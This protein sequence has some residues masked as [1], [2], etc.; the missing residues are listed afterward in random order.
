MKESDIEYFEKERKIRN[1][2]FFDRFPKIKYKGLKILDLGCGHGAISI[3]LVIKG[4]KKIIGVDVN[5]KRID[6]AKKNLLI[7]F[8]MFTDNINFECVDFRTISDTDFDYIISKASFEH[9]IELDKMLIDMKN[10]LKIGGK[11]IVGFGPLYNSPWGDHNRLKHKL[12]WAHIFFSEKYF[13][14][15]LNKH[16]E[17][18]I[19]SIYDLGLNGYSLK[20]YIDLFN[21]TEGFTVIDF[22][23]NVSKKVLMKVFNLFTY[24]P[25]L[26]E[27]FTYNIYCVLERIK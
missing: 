4:A 27:Y 6:F 1:P 13:I 16:R 21:N 26:R 23:T 18:K 11:L 3:D 10:K 9:F 5:E 22:R 14:N 20:K 8:P 12:P 15:K 25:I 17:K 19:T 7:N 2:I 24:I